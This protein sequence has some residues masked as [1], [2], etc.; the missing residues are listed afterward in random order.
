MNNIKFTP[1]LMLT[2]ET[3]NYKKDKARKRFGASG[4]LTKPFDPDR[5]NNAVGK[6]L[7]RSKT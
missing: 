5:L 1:V 6:L 3:S 7:G 2:T 4:W